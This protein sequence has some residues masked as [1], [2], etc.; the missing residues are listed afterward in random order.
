MDDAYLVDFQNSIVNNS[1]EAVI[2]IWLV[3]R[4]TATVA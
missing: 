3:G 1:R 2:S 4:F